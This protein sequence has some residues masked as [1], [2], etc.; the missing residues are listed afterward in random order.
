MIEIAKFVFNPF[1]ENTYIVWDKE[2]SEAI[3]VDPGCYDSFEESELADFISDN[4]LTVKYLVVTHGHIDHVLGVNFIKHKYNP[5]Y[6]APEADIPLLKMT[7]KQGAAFGIECGVPVMPDLYLSEHSSIE[8]GSSEIFP[9]FTPG[10][11][12]GEHCLYFKNEAFCM[13]GDVLFKGSIGRTDLWSGDYD[14]LIS[15]IRDRLF[16]LPDDTVIYPGHGDASR[17]GIEKKENPFVKE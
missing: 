4:K 2:K 6:L 1:S 12:P 9:L 3:I 16:I 15:S 5:V 13:C 14:T 7:D 8:L 11:S 10:H 17:I